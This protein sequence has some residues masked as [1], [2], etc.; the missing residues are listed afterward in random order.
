M[1]TEDAEGPNDGVPFCKGGGVFSKG[2][3]K[4]TTSK[5]T[6]PSSPASQN[7]SSY[8]DT[9][10]L[11][12][13]SAPTFSMGQLSSIFSN[14]LAYVNDTKFTRTC[15]VVSKI[16]DA[17]SLSDESLQGAASALTPSFQFALGSLN[18]RASYAVTNDLHR[19]VHHLEAEKQ[20]LSD[21][22]STYKNIVTNL[23]ERNQQLVGTEQRI[24]YENKSLKSELSARNDKCCRLKKKLV[25]TVS[26]LSKDVLRVREAAIKKTAMEICSKHSIPVQN[27][28]F[29]E[30]PANE[31]A[32]DISDSDAE[33]EECE[34]TEDGDDGRSKTGNN[35]EFEEERGEVDMGGK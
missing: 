15:N 30:V 21:E 6:K 9:L 14:S 1:E 12:D 31:E 5:K 4:K 26:N 13:I 19:R 24:L 29:A 28:G 3:G 27:Y 33:S 32:S 8:D 2:H 35:P 10:P 34:E 17:P 18:A 7:T 23:R 11:P 25:V 22:L 20:K 16:C